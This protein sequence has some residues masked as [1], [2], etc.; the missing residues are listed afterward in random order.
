MPAPMPT[1]PPT[2][3]AAA[4]ERDAAEDE[5]PHYLPRAGREALLLGGALLFGVVVMPLLIWLVGDRI[6]GPYT[7]GQNL[8]AG[9]FALLQDFF[10]GLGHG[11]AV[12]WAVALG[13][14]V[15]LLLLRL[16]VR[17][18]RVLPGT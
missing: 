3:A 18:L 13:P 11:S 16:F 5:A 4:R 7:H 12:F 9:A 15:L 2:E 10:V 17:L 14:L 1:P 8:H 6:L